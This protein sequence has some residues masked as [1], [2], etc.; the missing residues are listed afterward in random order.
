MFD[1]NN[2]HKWF[3]FGGSL[4]NLN[5]VMRIFTSEEKPSLTLEY[6]H[7]TARSEYVFNNIQERDECLEKIWKILNKNI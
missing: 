1:K 6:S 4:V 2:G 7:A 3:S 5:Y